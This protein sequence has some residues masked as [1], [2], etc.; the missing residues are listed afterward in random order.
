MNF[1]AMPLFFF[2]S[3]LFGCRIC[4]GQCG[5]G[6]G[7]DGLRGALSGGFA[8]GIATDFAIL[9]TPAA[10]LLAIGAWLFSILRRSDAKF[11]PERHFPPFRAASE[12]RLPRKVTV[13][14]LND[15]ILPLFRSL[16]DAGPEVSGGGK[17]AF[18]KRASS[19]PS[20]RRKWSAICRCQ[21]RP[22]A[23]SSP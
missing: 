17:G 8:F 2:S 22:R 5:S 7:V 21:S 4:R 15:R 9:G 23:R 3:A 6:Y 13:T 14:F 10:I 18:R 1:I 16:P 12:R 11:Y 19:R 20:R